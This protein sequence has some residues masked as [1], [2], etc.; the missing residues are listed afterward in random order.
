M[1]VRVPPGR[2]CCWTGRIGCGRRNH[3]R[4]GRGHGHRMACVASTAAGL[5]AQG[6]VQCPPIAGLD[7]LP[8]AVV[9]EGGL[10]PQRGSG[11]LRI[12]RIRSCRLRQRG[13]W[14]AKRHDGRHPAKE[15]VHRSKPCDSSARHR[16]SQKSPVRLGI[17]RRTSP[18]RPPSEALRG[19]MV[20]GGRSCPSE[21]KLGAGV[22]RS[23][24]LTLGSA[25]GSGRWGASLNRG[26]NEQ[27][28]EHILH[29]SETPCS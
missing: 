2:R 12:R 19:Q 29:L 8:R 11:R 1:V 5:G 25:I 6:V 27:K 7:V 18:I 22:D 4:H 16:R 28:A 10:V 17:R 23:G 21:T 3:G 26:V 24:N 9:G 13:Q 20:R 15:V 14:Q